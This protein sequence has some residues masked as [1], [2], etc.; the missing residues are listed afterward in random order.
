MEKINKKD[1]IDLVAEEAFLTK[2]DAKAALDVCFEQISNFL[3]AG[4][5]I[6][7]SNFGTFTPKKNPTRKGT[8]PKNHSIIEIKETNKVSFKIS[9]NLK[10]KLNKE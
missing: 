10:E 7:I 2:K 4:Y 5:E 8:H 6:N 3:L 9:K 1:L